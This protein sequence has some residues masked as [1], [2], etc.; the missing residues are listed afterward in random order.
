M[1]A[2]LA[3][4]GCTGASTARVAQSPAPTVTFSPSDATTCVSA[5]SIAPRWQGGQPLPHRFCVQ[6]G[7]TIT[8][9]ALTGTIST[10][11]SRDD[12]VLTARGLTG[13]LDHVV[14]RAVGRGQ[15]LLSVGLDMNPGAPTSGRSFLVRVV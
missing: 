6:R 8:F 7:G 11:D 4:T 10:V 5:R 3:A 12:Q 9:Y 13:E 14:V 1:T 15:T 2:L